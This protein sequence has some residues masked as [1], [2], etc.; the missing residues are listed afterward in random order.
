M[1]LPEDELRIRAYARDS[2]NLQMLL[3]EID[4]LRGEQKLYVELVKQLEEER[5]RLR[6]Q[7]EQ[8]ERE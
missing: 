2:V 6:E 8:K 4:K 3:A 7:L 5:D 1:L